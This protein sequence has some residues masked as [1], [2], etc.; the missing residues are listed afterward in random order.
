MIDAD[1]KLKREMQAIEHHKKQLT[2]INMRDENL[3]LVQ[4]KATRDLDRNG[5]SLGRVY[6]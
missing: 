6:L 3:K 5:S 2:T 4:E 1:I